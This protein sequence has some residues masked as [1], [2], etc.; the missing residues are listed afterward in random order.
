MHNDSPVNGLDAQVPDAAA[1]SPGDRTFQAAVLFGQSETQFWMSEYAAEPS[2]QPIGRQRFE[3]IVA[4]R[5]PCY[6]FQETS[7]AARGKDHYGN[8]RK[9]EEPRP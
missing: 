8:V 3:L 4:Y 2:R 9:L 1:G 6:G 5:K 7:I